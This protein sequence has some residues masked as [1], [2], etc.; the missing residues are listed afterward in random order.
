MQIP[1]YVMYT[2]AHTTNLVCEFSNFL[3]QTKCMPISNLSLACSNSQLVEIRWKG[4]SQGMSR[5]KFHWNLPEEQKLF[6]KILM[7]SP[8]S[9]RWESP[10]DRGGLTVALLSDWILF[11]SCTVCAVLIPHESPVL[12]SS[13]E[14]LSLTQPAL[15]QTFLH[16]GTELSNW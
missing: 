4:G 13:H 11:S 16:S 7:F 10:Q 1:T 3:R 12:P 8:T 9:P 15:E 14:N 6:N 5:G 2:H